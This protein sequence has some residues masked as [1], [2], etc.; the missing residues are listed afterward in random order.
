MDETLP[1]ETERVLRGFFKDGR[2]VT[3]PAKE[4][5]R[6]VVLRYLRD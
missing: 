3:I 4:R 1:P 6:L 2:L 5:K